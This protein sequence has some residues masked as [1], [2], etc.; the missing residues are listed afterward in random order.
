MPQLR[1]QLLFLDADAM[2]HQKYPTQTIYHRLH[3]LWA[4]HVQ[5][6]KSLHGIRC[7]PIHRLSLIADSILL[8]C[9]MLSQ[10]ALLKKNVRVN[11]NSDE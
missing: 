1:K 10:P 7:C 11:V 4:S 6:L 2:H 8:L 9:G 5:F 3:W